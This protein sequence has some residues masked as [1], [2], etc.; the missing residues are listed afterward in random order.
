MTR[1]V[2]F[3]LVVAALSLSACGGPCNGPY[4]GTWSGSS[5][6][7]TLAASCEFSYLGPDGCR[8]DGE[9]ASPLGSSGSVTVTI[10]SSTGGDCQNAGSYV[11]SYA[12]QGSALGLNCGGGETLYS[13]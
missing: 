1:V 5:G 2:T 11:C 9:Y 7:L 3:F 8:S 10:S 12:V 4:A 6:T 13:R